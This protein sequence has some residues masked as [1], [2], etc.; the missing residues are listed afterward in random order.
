[1]EIREKVMGKLFALDEALKPTLPALLALLDASV[2]TLLLREI[3]RIDCEVR[4]SRATAR[5]CRSAA[6]SFDHH[7]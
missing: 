1:M 6:R 3:V 4:A 5:A 2:A 7:V